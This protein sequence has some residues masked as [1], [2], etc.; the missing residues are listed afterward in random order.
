MSY[1][2]LITSYPKNNKELKLETRADRK[3]RKKRK[4]KENTLTQL[5][6]PLYLLAEFGIK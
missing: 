2:V 1:M 4:G 3:S 6:N 5:K